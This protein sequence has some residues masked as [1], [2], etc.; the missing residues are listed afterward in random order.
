MIDFEEH[1]FRGCTFLDYPGSFAFKLISDEI[2]C[3]APGTPLGHKGAPYGLV[4]GDVVVDIGAHIGIISIL[5]AKENPEVKFYAFEPMTPIFDA[6]VQNIKI[7]DVPNVI[8][9]HF[10]VAGEECTKTMAHNLMGN[11]AGSSM[12]IG[13]SASTLTYPEKCITADQLW[14]LT[15]RADIKLLKM[16]CEGAE[17]EFV[18]ASKDSEFWKHVTNCVGELHEN[19]LL[20]DM[21]YTN[22]DTKAIIANLVSGD[23]RF[24][25]IV[26]A[27]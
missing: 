27:Q 7:N 4:S 22:E 23:I 11:S 1:E 10:G 6:L 15:G 9:F 20:N 12:W 14:E 13:D 17:H 24:Q 8:P 25:C 26:M 5:L 3:T 18:G 16:D 2:E 21:G 19:K